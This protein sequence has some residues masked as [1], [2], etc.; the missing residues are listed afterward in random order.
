VS[1]SVGARLFVAIDPPAAV[2]DELAAWT[3][4][5]LGGLRGLD[6]GP[7]RAGGFDKVRLLAPE[8]MH[9][10]LCFLAERPVGEIET[11][12]DALRACP[13]AL[14]HELSLGGPLWL[15]PRR[16]RALALAVHDRGDELERLHASVCES[17]SQAIDWRAERRRYRAHVTVARLNPARDKRERRRRREQ[18]AR[19]AGEAARAQVVEPALPVTPRLSFEPREIVL[20]RSWLS[21]RGAS[22]E[23]VAARTL[24]A[25]AVSSAALS[26]SSDCSGAPATEEPF[27]TI[28]RHAGGEPSSGATGFEPSSHSGVEPSSQT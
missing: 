17:L 7:A 11:I 2:C 14:E 21:P 19:E 1:R 22:Y 8:T 9:V 13:A 5:A 26:A 24:D 28:S 12:A 15:P 27:E 16:P 23:A 6:A 20:Y 25:S 3:R 10:T 4:A 18:S